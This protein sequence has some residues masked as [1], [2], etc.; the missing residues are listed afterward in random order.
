LK[1]QSIFLTSL[2]DDYE[3]L[4]APSDSGIHKFVI[5]FFGNVFVIR[6]FVW[7]PVL[8][9]QKEGT[10]LISSYYWSKR[11]LG[12][13]ATKNVA[14][15]FEGEPYEKIRETQPELAF[16]LFLLD[17][18]LQETRKKL[19]A[20]KVYI[21]NLKSY[22][23][24]ALFSVVIRALTEIGAKWGDAKL[25]EQLHW[26]KLTKAC[27][28]HVLAAFEKES[29]GY[30]KREGE[31]LTYANYFKNQGAMDRMLSRPLGTHL[32]GLARNALNS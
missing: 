1:K 4:L 11:H 5:G 18:P 14:Q 16:Q 23:Y 20:K 26:E 2:T 15:L 9:D 6:V 32:R 29:R 28:D 25:T 17:D 7:G 22:A 8:Y 21:R 12:P 30:R 19:A 27:I 10:Q 31:E 3:I 13:A 24:F